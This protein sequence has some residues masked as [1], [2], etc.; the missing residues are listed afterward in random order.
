LN[1]TRKVGLQK[2]RKRIVKIHAAENNTATLQKGPRAEKAHRS[3]PRSLA[4]NPR[5]R[6]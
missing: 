4:L 5:P 2:R 1:K 3:E 6:R